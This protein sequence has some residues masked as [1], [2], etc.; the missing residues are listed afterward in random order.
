MMTPE[1]PKNGEHC[2]RLSSEPLPV[3]LRTAANRHGGS[4]SSCQSQC[5][6]PCVCDGTLREPRGMGMGVGLRVDLG[7][8]MD[9]CAGVRDFNPVTDDQETPRHSS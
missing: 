1:C 8:D 7:M 9:A 3:F 4:R 5:Q 2:A 6:Q